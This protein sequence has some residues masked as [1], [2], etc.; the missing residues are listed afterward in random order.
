M[1]K[2][3]LERENFKKYSNG[4]GYEITVDTSDSRKCFNVFKVNEIENS[5]YLPK[6][7]VENYNEDNSYNFGIINHIQ[8]SE[9]DIDKAIEAYKSALKLD[10][11]NEEGNYRLS[12]CYARKGMWEKCVNCCKKVLEINSNSALA[13]NQYGLA[14]FCREDFDNSIIMYRKALVIQPDFASAYYNIGNVYEKQGDFKAAVE[15]LR[16]YIELSS[17]KDNSHLKTRIKDLEASIK[18]KA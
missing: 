8:S 5:Q 11:K 4:K 15:A 2:L 16:K 17:D 12:I 7:T 1:L 18:L 10:A 13:Y 9:R 14:L 6:I 3:N